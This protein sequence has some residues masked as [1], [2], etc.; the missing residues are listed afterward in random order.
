MRF[1]VFSLCEENLTICPS[2]SF[3][4]D[5]KLPL[6]VEV[7]TSFDKKFSGFFVIMVSSRYLFKNVYFGYYF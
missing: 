5:K 3:S 1:P 2:G 4:K 7:G 6:L